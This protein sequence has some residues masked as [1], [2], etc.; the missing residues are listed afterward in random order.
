MIRTPPSRHRA[1]SL[2]ELMLAIALLAVLAAFLFPVVQGVRKRSAQVQCVANLGQISTA[3]AAYGVDHR[4]QWPDNGLHADSVNDVFVEAL[5]PYFGRVPKTGE[6]DFRRSPFI[7]P[8]ERSDMPDGA[9][10]KDGVYVVRSRG[11]SYAQ[12][13]YLHETAAASRVGLRTALEHPSALVLYM[14]FPKHFVL[15]ISRLGKDNRVAQLKE[16][17]GERA[18]AA[19]AD[20]S[21]RPVAIDEIPTT[22]PSLFWQGRK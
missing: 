4:G 21:V 12:N 15:D 17:H 14:D 19:F 9:Y 3:S 18:N 16:R 6:S 11:L 20:G 13:G 2:A 5:V 10:Q 22:R 8:A 1:F 7:C